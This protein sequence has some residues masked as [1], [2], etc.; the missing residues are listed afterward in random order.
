MES[1]S[2]GTIRG[3]LLAWCLLYR[4][5]WRD[6][7]IRWYARSKIGRLSSADKAVKGQKAF[8]INYEATMGPPPCGVAGIHTLCMATEWVQW[9]CA[10]R[11]GLLCY[12]YMLLLLWSI[13]IMSLYQYNILICYGSA[14]WPKVIMERVWFQISFNFESLYN[15]VILESQLTLTFQ[16]ISPM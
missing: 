13:I 9:L 5:D 1:I 6:P 3:W 2:A 8:A 16:N 10:T 12:C 11:E 4:E 15:W 7:W 14:S